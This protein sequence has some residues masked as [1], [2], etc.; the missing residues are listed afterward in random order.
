MSQTTFNICQA[1]LKNTYKH[2]TGAQLKR[3]MAPW[4]HEHC[5]QGLNH[6]FLGFEVCGSTGEHV[7][8]H[9]FGDFRAAN[10]QR[11]A[12]VL[13]FAQALSQCVQLL[14]HLVWARVTDVRET[15]VDLLQELAHLEGRVNVAVAHAADAQPHQLSGQVGHTQQ[16]VGGRHLEGQDRL[17]RALRRKS[18]F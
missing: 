1:P 3:T 11:V 4:E 17:D 7:G 9:V 13:H 12:G 18:L 14:G 15:V 6:S 5:S 10:A 2:Q 8:Q 16:V